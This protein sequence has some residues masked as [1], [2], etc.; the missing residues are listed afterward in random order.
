M[1]AL[2]IADRPLNT[3]TSASRAHDKQMGLFVFAGMKTI[4]HTVISRCC[5]TMS[6]T[7]CREIRIAILATRGIVMVRTQRGLIGLEGLALALFTWLRK[8]R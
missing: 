7:P 8:N 1:S 2:N 6:V 3:N 5:L 4:W